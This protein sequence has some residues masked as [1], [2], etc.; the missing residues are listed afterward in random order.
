MNPALFLGAIVLC[1]GSVIWGLSIAGGPDYAR[2]QDND[3]QRALHLRDLVHYIAC[4]ETDAAQ[5]LQPSEGISLV[6]Q[7]CGAGAD[8]RP[9]LRDPV[10]DQPYTITQRDDGTLKACAIFEI[11]NAGF[12]GQRYG[13]ANKI[14]FDGKTGCMTYRYTKDSSGNMSWR[15]N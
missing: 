14:A 7:R 9:D 2:M 13:P 3:R 5:G 10:T 1:L 8:V 11:G 4:E 6:P 15:M 12:E